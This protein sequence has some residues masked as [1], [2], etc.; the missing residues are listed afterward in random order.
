MQTLIKTISYGIKISGLNA[1]KFG[2]R[3]GRMGSRPQKNL[4]QLLNENKEVNL[5]I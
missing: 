1:N 5:K 4:G 2:Y 3:F